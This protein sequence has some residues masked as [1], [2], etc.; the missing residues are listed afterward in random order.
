[1]ALRIVFMGTPDFAVPMLSAIAA[2]GH[3]IAAVYTRAPRPSG[4]GM[5]LQAS[6]VEQEARRL[7]V[8]VFAP[9]SLRTAESV[10]AFAAQ[11]AD[12]AVVVAYGLI[13]PKPILDAPRLGCF[14]L[15]ASAL[16]RWR[17]AAPINRAI[18][19][20]DDET[21]VTVMKMEPG[22]DTGPVA[23]MQRVPIGANMTAKELHDRLAELGAALMGEALMALE[24]G[25]L[26]LTAQASTG[27][28]YAPKIE[29][30]ETRIDWRKPWKS[31]HDHCRGLSPHPGAW[32]AFPLAPAARPQTPQTPEGAGLRIKVLRTTK[33][34]GEGEPGVAIDDRLTIACGHG[35]VRILELQRA[36]RAP[37]GAD[38]FLLGTPV[39]PGTRLG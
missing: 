35:A 22:L 33:G 31:V 23:M 24:H 10:A 28:T 2:F 37:M 9:V 18:M 26:Q 14:N 5:R 19:A 25:T 38:A 17:G 36:G 12:A 27:I 3:E 21:A 13:L 29:N 7:G 1:M 39:Q 30:N 6:P 20:G 8:A 15:H 4:R 32:F 11:A 34:E 16:P